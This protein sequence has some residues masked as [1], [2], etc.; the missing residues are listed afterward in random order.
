LAVYAMAAKRV[1]NAQLAADI[2]AMRYRD[3]V[4]NALDFRA[5]DVALLQAEAAELAARQEW[6]AAHWEVLRLV[7]G[8]RSG[9]VEVKP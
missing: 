7:G 9:T 4:L 2:G 6:S 5:L 8:L 1:S 3:G